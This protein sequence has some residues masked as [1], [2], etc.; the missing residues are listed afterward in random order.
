MSL[1]KE[2]QGGTVRILCILKMQHH[3]T[4]GGSYTAIAYRG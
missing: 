2:T 4:R 1:Q 3:C